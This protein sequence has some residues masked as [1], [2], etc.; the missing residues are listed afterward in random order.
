MKTETSN[1]SNAAIQWL[2]NGERGSSSNALF[3]GLTGI[4]AGSKD[5]YPHDPGDF[6]R[7]RLLIEQCPELKPFLHKMKTARPAWSAL[8]EHWEELCAVMDAELPGWRNGQGKAEKT[9]QFMRRIFESAGQK[10]VEV[11]DGVLTINV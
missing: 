4:Y 5:S 8:V 6:R 3:Y 9:Y 1:L 11:V 10:P 2:A 7:C